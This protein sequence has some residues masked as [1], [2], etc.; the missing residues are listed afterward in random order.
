MKNKS[1]FAIFNLLFFIFILSA[2]V[3]RNYLDHGVLRLVLAVTMIASGMI[4]IIV[5]V[6]QIIMEYKTP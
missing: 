2:F 6:L 4:A 5:N 3:I 1:K